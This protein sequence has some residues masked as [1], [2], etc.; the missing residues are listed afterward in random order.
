M[1]KTGTTYRNTYTNSCSLV[2]EPGFLHVRYNDSP[3]NRQ[4]SLFK[5]ER[6]AHGNLQH[7]G[8][9]LANILT[10]N[11]SM[12]CYTPWLRF[13]EVLLDLLEDF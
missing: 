6:N 9:A 8:R 3:K 1:A 5:P 10:N 4:F 2:G 13:S 12:I 7:M 11:Q